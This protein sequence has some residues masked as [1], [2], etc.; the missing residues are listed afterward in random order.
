MYKR[1]VDGALGEEDGLPTV[2]ASA[3]L[4]AALGGRPQAEA[5]VAVE[6]AEAVAAREPR[7]A[8]SPSDPTADEVEAH[9]LSGHACFRS[10]CR[11][12]VRGRGAEAAHSSSKPP[13]TALPVLSF[14]YCYLS[15]REEARASEAALAPTQLVGDSP[16][17]TG[18]EFRAESP[19][20]VMWD[21]RG[22]GLHAHIVPAKG[23]DYEGFEKVLRLWS[24]DLELS[25]IHI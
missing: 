6:E 17:S 21:S 19:V 25:L 5:Q 7:K 2:S 22:K 1:Q 23:T 8:P 11:H 13:P 9:K 14:D 3:E 4:A 16:T 10:W 24:A 15:T 12:C 18:P 20:L